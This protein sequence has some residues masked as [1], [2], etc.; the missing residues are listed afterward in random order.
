MFFEFGDILG[1]ERKLDSFGMIKLKRGRQI[2]LGGGD[3]LKSGVNE[4]AE[5]EFVG[6]RFGRSAQETIAVEGFGAGIDQINETSEISSSET[7]AFEAILENEAQIGGHDSI[8]GRPVTLDDAEARVDIEILV[9]GLD[10]LAS[11]GEVRRDL[12]LGFF[13]ALFVEIA[14]TGS[15]FFGKILNGVGHDE[16][17]LSAGNC[18]EEEA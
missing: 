8:S 12:T 17:L 13:V 16:V 15:S 7:V 5:S 9:V 11:F 2:E 14:K 1:W 3:L 10:F 6:E 18:N 4:I